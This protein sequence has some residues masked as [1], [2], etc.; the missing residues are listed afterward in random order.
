MARVAEK[1]CSEIIL[2]NEDPYDEDPQ[3][4]IDEMKEAIKSKSVEVILDR[5]KA[6]NAA[7]KNLRKTMLS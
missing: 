7:L 4:I 1:Y 6:I 5:R 3:R 2:T